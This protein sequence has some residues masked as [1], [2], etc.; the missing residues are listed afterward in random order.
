[1]PNAFSAITVC[2]GEPECRT[3][4]AFIE[5]AV[6]SAKNARLRKVVYEQRTEK[7]MVLMGD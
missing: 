1:M 4:W 3:I 5:G 6:E 2:L 7:N